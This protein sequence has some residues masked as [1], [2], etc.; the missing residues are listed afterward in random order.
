[1]CEIRKEERKLYAQKQLLKS[2]E[3]NEKLKKKNAF[4]IHEQ[5]EKIED[6]QNFY[7]NFLIANEKIRK[8][9]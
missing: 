9:K 5:R 3:K 6:K 1:M 7:H 8:E 2:L 4:K